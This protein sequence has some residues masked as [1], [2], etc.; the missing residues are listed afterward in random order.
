MAAWKR[1]GN[2]PDDDAQLAQITRMADRWQTHASATVRAFFTQRDGML[3]HG[4][5]EAE[6][7]AA[8]ELVDKRSRAGAVGAAAKWQKDGKRIAD[9]IGDAL[10]PHRQT[11]TPS[12]SPSPSP[13]SP[14]GEEKRRVVRALTVDQLAADGLTEQTAVEFLA[15]R[16]RKGAALTPRAWDGIKRE[17]AAAG[18]PVEK[19]VAKCLARGWTGFEAAWIAGGRATTAQAPA[20]AK[21]A[22][23]EEHNA[24]VARRILARIDNEG[25]EAA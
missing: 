4:R 22:A 23:I 25:T 6:L 15:L 9:A 10:Q 7:Q 2:V 8:R 19:A 20:F 1:G 13:S 18:W 17:A 5:V 12:P 24:E 11:D 3:W 16:K 14:E 21:G